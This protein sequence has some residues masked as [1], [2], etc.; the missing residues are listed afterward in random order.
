MKVMKEGCL[1]KAT[2]WLTAAEARPVQ[3]NGGLQCHP[4]FVNLLHGLL[5]MDRKQMHTRKAS[6]G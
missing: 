5:V 1:P 3:T 4:Y 2:P 6:C